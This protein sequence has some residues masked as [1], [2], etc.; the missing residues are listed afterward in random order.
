MPRRC[1][2]LL[3]R[4]PRPRPRP[5][6]SAADRAAARPWVLK[7]VPYP[8]GGF[9]ELARSS[10][11]GRRPSQCGLLN[12]VYGGSAELRARPARQDRPVAAGDAPAPAAGVKARR[13]ACRL[14]RRRAARPRR[15]VGS[16][17]AV[18]RGGPPGRALW[19]GD[20]APCGR[21]GRP[22]STGRLL[23]RRVAGHA[24]AARIS[25]A[26]CS[27]SSQAWCNWPS[28]SASAMPLRAQKL[29]RVSVL[30]S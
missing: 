10:P 2:G 24:R 25:C 17:A 1:S 13:S 26:R 29:A 19:R 3:R 22:A 18:A 16:W 6:L 9:A 14:G 4:W 7:T 15:A 30:D 11:L 12:G 28:R 5:P 23:R 20:V 27:R 8:R 21:S